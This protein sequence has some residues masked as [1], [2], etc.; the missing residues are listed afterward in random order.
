M[1]DKSKPTAFLAYASGMPAFEE[2]IENAV[3]RLNKSN[4]VEILS[5][6]KLQIGGRI[7]I[8]S[9]CHEIDQRDIF[10]ADITKLNPNVLFELGY[11]I[12]KN[13]SDLPPVI[14]PTRMLVQR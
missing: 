7:L 8:A 12:A 4:A 3:D 5:W 6:N 9:I 1:T 2:T 13:R 11:A 10:I 14:V